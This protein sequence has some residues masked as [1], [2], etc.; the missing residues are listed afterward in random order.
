MTEWRR[1]RLELKPGVTGLWQVNGCS[2]LPFEEM[3]ALDYRY[4]TNWSPWLD[5]GLIMK[6]FSVV[7]RGAAEA[8]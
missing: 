1:R 6:T 8:Q 5:L 3:V 2:N 7:L 4:V